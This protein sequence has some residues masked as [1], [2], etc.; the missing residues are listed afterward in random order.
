[1]PKRVIV[2]ATKGSDCLATEICHHLHLRLPES[3]QP[4]GGLKLSRHE[5]T[6]FSNDNT[7]AQIPNVRG[8]F[9]VIIH[10]QTSPVND[11]LFELFHIL[12]AVCNSHPADVLL[13]MPY[14][15]YSRSDRKNQPRISVMGKQLPKIIS[16]F[17]VKRVL[18]LDPHD[19]HIKHYFDTDA[20]EITAQYLMVDYIE[21][22]LFSEYP[23][24][25]CSMAFADGGAAKRFRKM[26]HLLKLPVVHID[27]DRPDND[28]NPE[29]K[30]VIG[31]VKG[32]VCLMPEDEIAS[33]RTA[34]GTSDILIE[35]GAK[36]VIFLAIHP[37][38]NKVG[39]PEKTVVQLLEKSSI[40]RFVVTD[41]V[42]V[43]HKLGKKSKFR[44]L[45]SAPL[46]A[47]AIRRTVQ[48]DSL[49]T[50]HDP[51]GVDLYR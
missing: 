8:R 47:E 5:Y 32:R 13:V 26:A 34:I 1:M 22:V 50:L 45:P 43:F 3:A 14:M 48:N 21:R 46:L 28:E 29:F 7:M 10:T 30:A 42:P 2:F 24:D 12:D 39:Q 18:L 33:G 31:Q 17:G 6:R 4:D 37:V 25:H 9:V 23:R 38:L 16:Q 51:K 35:A 40:A 44:V 11:R 49:T 15:P 36:A 41:S 20:D 27:K 19:S